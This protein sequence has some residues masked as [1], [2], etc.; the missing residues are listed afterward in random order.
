M[1]FSYF[2]IG[3]LLLVVSNILQITTINNAIINDVL[4]FFGL[5]FLLINVISK[6]EKT[7][8]LVLEI[9]IFIILFLSYLKSQSDLM[10]V[11]FL[12]GI[13]VRKIKLKELIKKDLMIRIP[14]VTLI[15]LAGFFEIIPNIT[16]YMRGLYKNSLGFSHPNHLGIMLLVIVI[17]WFFLKH[18]KF[19]IYDYTFILFILLIA[20]NIAGSRTSGY[21]ILFIIS[22]EI[23]TSILNKMKKWHFIRIKIIG[24]I[25]YCYFMIPAVSVWLAYNFNPLIGWMTKL[26]GFM[27]GRLSLTFFAAKNNPLLLWGQSIEYKGGLSSNVMMEYRNAIDNSYI[28]I[29]LRLGILAFIVL[30]ISLFV[31]LNYF[32]KTNNISA[33]YSL[34]FMI[35]AAFSESTMF[36]ISHNAFLLCLIPAVKLLKNKK[37]LILRR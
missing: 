8:Y 5:A 16:F 19:K 10:I 4:N 30:V 26:D 35:I 18:L 36:E 31:L 14:L 2:D 25:K 28:Y 29:L 1:R 27:T 34:I 6:K 32:Q 37:N 24:F 13:A 3:Y 7:K 21:I 15:C 12:A 33:F 20:Y 23:L 11:V 22:F 9:L 17:Y